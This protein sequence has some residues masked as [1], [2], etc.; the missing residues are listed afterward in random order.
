MVKK[1]IKY[2]G[3]RIVEG[4]GISYS[5]WFNGRDMIP[6]LGNLQSLLTVYKQWSNSIND[7]LRNLDRWKMLSEDLEP[8]GGILSR[9]RQVRRYL[10]I[11]KEDS[12]GVE[13][14]VL[15]KG[16]DVGRCGKSGEMVAV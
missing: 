4:I 6:L 14:I 15:Q 10:E 11:R 2:Q 9:R 3:L 16:G 8:K 12:G 1:N 7:T 5:I 13:G